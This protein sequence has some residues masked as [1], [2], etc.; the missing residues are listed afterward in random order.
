MRICFCYPVEMAGVVHVVEKIS[1]KNLIKRVV[2]NHKR[3]AKE[4]IEL[5][6]DK[7]ELFNLTVK[8]LIEDF[9]VTNWAWIEDDDGDLI[10]NSEG[11]FNV[12]DYI[13]R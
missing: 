13:P 2:A 4:K 6:V 7:P 10:K 11:L 5:F 1:S 9:I 12:L 3:M 8:D